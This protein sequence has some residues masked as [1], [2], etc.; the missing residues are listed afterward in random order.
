M[1][2]IDFCAIICST[3]LTSYDG[4]LG[5]ELSEGQQEEL[6]TLLRHHQTVFTTPS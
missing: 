3:E 5:A 6:A 2:D 1:N 4:E